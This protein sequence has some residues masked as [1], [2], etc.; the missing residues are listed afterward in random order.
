MKEKRGGMSGA[1]VTLWGVR[2]SGKWGPQEKSQKSES[3][4]VTKGR[5]EKNTEDIKKGP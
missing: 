5:L 1:S 3:E 2:K 4:H